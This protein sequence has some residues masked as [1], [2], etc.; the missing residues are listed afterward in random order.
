[1]MVVGFKSGKG[2]DHVRQ[3]EIGHPMLGNSQSYMSVIPIPNSFC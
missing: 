1:M 2:V 3:S